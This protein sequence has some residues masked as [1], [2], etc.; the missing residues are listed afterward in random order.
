MGLHRLGFVGAVQTEMYF[1]V[2]QASD[3]IY[4]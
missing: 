1:N 3:L 4:N 2:D